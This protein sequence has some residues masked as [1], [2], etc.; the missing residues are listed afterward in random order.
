MVSSRRFRK[1]NSEKQ[2]AMGAS[3]AFSRAVSL[4]NRGADAAWNPQSKKL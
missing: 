3:G 1:E 2:K 4:E